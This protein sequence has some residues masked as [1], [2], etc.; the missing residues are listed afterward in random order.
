[1]PVGFAR[2]SCKKFEAYKQKK[3]ANHGEVEGIFTVDA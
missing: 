2:Q 3:N 1:M